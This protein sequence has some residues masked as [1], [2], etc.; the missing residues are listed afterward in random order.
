MSE[1][2]IE[3]RNL[4]KIFKIYPDKSNSIKEKILFF[5]RNKYDVNQVLDGVSFD[6]KKGEAVGLIGKNGCGKSTTLKLLNRIMYPTSGTIRVNGRVSSLIELGAGFHPDMSGR[7]NIYTNASIFGLTKKQIDEKLDDIIEFSELGE[8]VDNPVRTYSSGMYMRLAF[9]VAINVEADVLLID[10]ILAV[11]DVSFQKKCFE[12]L[13]EI[14]YSGTTIVIVSHSLQQIEQI[15]DK[16]IWIEKGHIRQIGNPKEIHLK[17][18][19]EMEEERQRLIHEAQKN[20]ENDIE[21]RDSFCGKKV[22]R[23]GS[24]E[25]YFTNVT[26]K[27]K[28]EKLQNVYKSHDFM[29]VQ[30]DFVNKSDIEEA[31]FSVRIYKDDNTHCYGTTSDI[32]CN[33]TIKIKG[34]NKFIVDFDDLCL[35]DGN[36]MIDVDVKDKTGDIVYDSIHDTIRFD[37]IN[38]DGRTGVCAIRTSWKVE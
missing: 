3:V 32:E 36:Y 16:S 18:L 28:E 6:I 30:Y 11:G 25:V 2:A 17:Y 37:V 24:G 34:K 14:K 10:E 27:D 21:D 38:E 8:A 4:K 20:K 31:V 13:R 12:K 33:D 7:E 9:S 15:C 26:L 5:K 29:Q 22:I 23:S 35:L 1:N 19:K